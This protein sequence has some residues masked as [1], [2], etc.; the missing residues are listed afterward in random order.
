[1]SLKCINCWYFEKQ[2]RSAVSIMLTPLSHSEHK[3]NDGYYVISKQ[4]HTFLCSYG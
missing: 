4:L 1:M 2:I 3:M